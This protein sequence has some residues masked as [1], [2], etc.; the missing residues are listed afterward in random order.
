M[1]WRRSVW[2]EC[3]DGGLLSL[4][5]LSASARRQWNGVAF[6]TPSRVTPACVPVWLR[7]N[8]LGDPM[9][10]KRLVQAVSSRPSEAGDQHV[11]CRIVEDGLERLLFRTLLLSSAL[12]GVWLRRRSFEG[13]Q[14]GQSVARAVRELTAAEGQ[15]RARPCAHPR[16]VRPSTMSEQ[17]SRARALPRTSLSRALKQH[18]RSHATADMRLTLTAF[19]AGWRLFVARR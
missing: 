5:S 13:G 9:L 4:P 16:P 8:G 2:S 15:S 10:T 17:P 18:D 7:G 19:E 6:D 11:L 12:G 14:L 1:G 3:V